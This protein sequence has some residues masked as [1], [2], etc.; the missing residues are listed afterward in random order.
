M[1]ADIDSGRD[2]YMNIKEAKEEIVRTIRAYTAKDDSGCYRIPTVRQRPVLLIGPPGIGKTAIMEQAAAECGTGLIAYTITHH[3][4]Q[5]AVGLPQLTNRRFGDA[6][7]T[8]T[9]YTMSEIVGSIYEYEERTGYREGILFIDEINCVSETLA[10]TMLQF[11]Q[12]K[13]FG[14]HKVP[15]GWI[16]MAAGNPKEY[17][18]SVR[19]LDMAASDR[20]RTLNVEAD[21]S[22]WKE[23]ALGR[24]VHPTVL[25][26]LELHPEHFYQVTLTREKSEFVTARGWEDLSAVL[27]EYERQGLAVGRD[28]MEEFLRVPKIASDFASYYQFAKAHLLVCRMTELLEG[29]LSEEEERALQN[30]LAG[31]PGDT[32]CMFVRH[33][34]S[35]ASER[36]TAYGTGRRVLDRKTEVLLQLAAHCKEPRENAVEDFLK[37][38]AHALRVRKENDLLKP[39]EERMELLVDRWLQEKAASPAFVLLF[40]RLQRETLPKQ[41]LLALTGILKEQEMLQEQREELHCFLNRMTDFVRDAFGEELELTDWLYGIQNHGDQKLVA[42]LRPEMDVLLD[43]KGQEERLRKKI[44]EMEELYEA[45]DRK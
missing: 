1:G 30:R 38:R 27:L 37:K 2:R 45:A 35:A 3:T 21:Y 13:M 44:K 26:Y 34:L 32:R 43:Q 9:E 25:S 31:M 14:S 40:E 17:N 11:L 28:F 5:S 6:E 23:Y 7:Y 16:I 8:M 39:W 10:P 24:G 41:E 4:R 33:L 36:M 12:Y 42:F 19:E 15:E 18:R 22:V 29:R 20:V